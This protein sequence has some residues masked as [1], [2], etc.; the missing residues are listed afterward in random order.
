MT[1]A[2]HAFTPHRTVNYEGRLALAAQTVMD[3]RPLLDGPLVVEVE[4]HMPIA[5]SKPA[6]WKAAALA[7][8]IR[9]V[10]KPDLDNIAKIAGDA[11]NLVVWVDDSQI[12]RFVLEKHYSDNPRLVMKVRPHRGGVFE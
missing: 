8:E 3:G 11:L 10:K 1:R 9:P 6:K 7:G 2:G 5:V 4:A 12:V